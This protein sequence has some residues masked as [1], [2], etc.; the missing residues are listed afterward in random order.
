RQIRVGEAEPVRGDRIERRR[1]SRRS[2]AAIARRVLA[3]RR[4]ALGRRSAPR[5]RRW[6]EEAF[7]LRHRRDMLHVLRRLA[8]V[9]E[10]RL[11]AD[12]GVDRP[13]RR[14]LLRRGADRETRREH[15]EVQKPGGTRSHYWRSLRIAWSMAPMRSISMR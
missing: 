13:D 4:L 7:R 1:L 11:Q 3:S 9:V 5:R 15:R 14:N 6:I 2:V 10:S 12:A 8:G